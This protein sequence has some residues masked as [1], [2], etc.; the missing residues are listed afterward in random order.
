MTTLG[1][2]LYYMILSLQVCCIYGKIPTRFQNHLWFLYPVDSQ[3]IGN[4]ETYKSEND[5]QLQGSKIVC[6]WLEQ[7]NIVELSDPNSV[8]Q[9]WA[10]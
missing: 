3:R 2:D 5:Q 4:S 7:L 1:R 9:H 8:C 6:G 10:F